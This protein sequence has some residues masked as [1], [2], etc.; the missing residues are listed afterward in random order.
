M[1]DEFCLGCRA[2]RR[3]SLPKFGRSSKPAPAAA[4]APEPVPAPKPKRR[5][6]PLKAIL[7]GLLVVVGIVVLLRACSG[8]DEAEVR[9]TVERFAEASRDKDVQT[10]CDDLLSTVDVQE[11]R[12]TGQPCEVALGTGLEDV[13]NPTVEIRD[14]KIDGDEAEVTVDS[15]A[16]GQRPST[17]TVKL[18]KEDDG[19]R[20]LLDLANEGPPDPAP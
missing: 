5:R 6:P 3:P 16:A 12:S 8:D 17:D 18:Q 13:Q 10:L 11:L 9:T 15:S 1:T 19:W 7:I 4:A 14:V 2:M 20:I